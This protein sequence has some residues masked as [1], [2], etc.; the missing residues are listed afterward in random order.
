[1]KKV[2]M[3][4]QLCNMPQSCSALRWYCTSLK[5]AQNHPELKVKEGPKP[6]W[7]GCRGRRKGTWLPSFKPLDYLNFCRIM[8][9]Y[10]KVMHLFLS[11]P[12]PMWFSNP[13]V[14]TF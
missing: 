13:E 7:G 10:L 11:L 3:I 6:G 4:I 14:I 9:A 8:I 1:M 5:G 2:F 12:T